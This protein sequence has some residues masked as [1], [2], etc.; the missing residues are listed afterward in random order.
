MDKII[1]YQMVPRVAM[2]RTPDPAPDG[3]IERNGSGK[4]AD[5]NGRV[6]RSLRQMGI[7]HMW[8][9][10]VIEHAHATDYTA[11]GITPA[12]NPHVVKGRAGSPYAIRDYYDVD[13]D[14]AVDPRRRMAEMEALIDRTHSSGMKVVIDF[15]PNHVA[16][17][18]VTDA[19]PADAPAPFGADDDTSRFFSP[20]NDFYYLPG[21]SLAPADFSLGEGPGAYTECPARASGNDCF[22]AHPSR[23]DWYETVKL[24]YGV[25]PGRGTHFNPIPPL[26]HKMLH[27]LLYWAQ[28][29][30]DA[31]RCD[32]VHMVPV[33]FW[34]WAIAAVKERYPSAVFIA[35]IYQPELYSSYIEWGGFDYLYDKV[36]LYD[37][38]RAIEQG[39]CPAS[40][41]TGCWQ[42]LGGLGPH[43]LNFLENHDEQRFASPQYASRADR[44]APSLVVSATLST[45]PM[46]IYYGQ[47]LG[48]RALDAEG[49]SG[50]DG[51]TTIFDYWSL[52]PLRRWLGTAASPAPSAGRLT[53]EEQHLRRFYARTLTLASTDAAIAE[54]S[55]FDLMY[56]NYQ[57]PG[58]DPTRQYYY[59]RHHRPSGRLLLIGVNFADTPSEAQVTI[60]GHAF[61]CLALPEGAYKAT[62]LLRGYLPA[63]DSRQAATDSEV[64]LRAD[65]PVSVMLAAHGAA[66]IELT[67]AH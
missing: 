11:C 4:L 63:E 40:A 9:T 17:L 16:R 31:F 57:S 21:E 58:L 28:K 29:G 49:F 55:M 12:D 64:T 33:E 30:V 20:A 3:T 42:R 67:P 7:T 62:D 39:Y 24:N 22:T 50:P 25:D 15:V 41:I 32:M 37:T 60:P 10:G 2:N 51:R 65:S 34:H 53:P 27:I 54:G 47:E 6:L 46:M 35:E 14:L 56:V 66:I 44:V 26:W 52:E 59:L 61:E 8:Y 48:E 13:P 18:Y 5:I 38:L 23:S 1:I 19:A 36:G 45:G 43:M